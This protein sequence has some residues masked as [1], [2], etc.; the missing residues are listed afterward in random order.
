MAGERQLRMRWI[1]AVLADH[2]GRLDAHA[3]AVAV[4]LW[5]HM[6]GAGVCWPSI[7][8]VADESRCS[9][10]TVT[11]RI[12]ALEETGFLAVTRQ[13]RRANTYTAVVASVAPGDTDSRRRVRRAGAPSVAPGDTDEPGISVS[14]GKL[15]VSSGELSVSSGGSICVTGCDVT[16]NREPV[17]RA[18]GRRSAGA[19]PAP[20]AEQ[21]KALSI[22]RRMI[23][24]IDPFWNETPDWMFDPEPPRDVQTRLLDRVASISGLETRPGRRALA[25]F[26]GTD[27]REVRRFAD[28]LLGAIGSDGLDGL[29]DSLP[30]FRSLVEQWMTDDAEAAADLDADEGPFG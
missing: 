26:D 10:N 11:A 4:A 21:A 23:D 6:D 1:D 20:T 18:A 19:S 2:S 30:G 29:A 15:S 13:P 5:S 9:P 17:N 3:V 22:A 8:L 25:E 12:D 7:R 27:S 14:R 16:E 28:A 24:V